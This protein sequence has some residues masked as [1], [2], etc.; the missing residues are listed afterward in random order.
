MYSFI[1]NVGGDMVGK[2]SDLF[3][4]EVASWSASLFMRDGSVLSFACPGVY[5]MFTFLR[6][7]RDRI[8][9]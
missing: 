4:E 5:S 8:Q 3:C 2:S 1:W 6:L 7:W 9:R